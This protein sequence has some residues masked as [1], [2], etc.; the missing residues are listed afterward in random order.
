MALPPL[1]LPWWN[2]YRWLRLDLAC[3]PIKR[4]S[5]LPRRGTNKRYSDRNTPGLPTLPKIFLNPAIVCCTAGLA[6]S[7]R[8]TVGPLSPPT[9]VYRDKSY[10][11]NRATSGATESGVFRS[12]PIPEALLFA[13][14]PQIPDASTRSC[15]QAAALLSLDP[16]TATDEMPR[17]CMQTGRF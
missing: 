8:F 14:W 6:S 3:A 4:V 2:E 15:L 9:S 10:G 13:R 1:N 5:K 17:A 16:S 7:K 12:F 11:C